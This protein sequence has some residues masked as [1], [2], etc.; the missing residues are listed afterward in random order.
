MKSKHLFTWLALL[1]CLA[2]IIHTNQPAA[3]QMDD[4]EEEL[5]LAVIAAA[6]L[7]QLFISELY[8]QNDYARGAVVEMR[9]GSIPDGEGLIFLALW[10]NGAWQVWF[11][12]TEEFR[13][14]MHAAPEG[15]VPEPLKVLLDYTNEPKPD[16][17]IEQQIN[18]SGYKLPWP[19]GVAYYISRAWASGSC[20]HA[21]QA[22]DAVMPIGREIVAARAGIV[23]TV[24]QQYDD[25]GCSSAN[26][27]NYIKIRHNPNDGLYDYYIHIGKNRSLVSPGQAVAQGQPIAYSDQIGYTCGSSTCP[28]GTCRNGSCNP[29]AHLHF[30]VSNSAGTRQYVRFDDVGDLVG[31]RT[32]TSG[33]YYGGRVPIGSG[34]SSVLYLDDANGDGHKDDLFLR[35]CGSNVASNRRYVLLSYPGGSRLLSR[36]ADG[37]SC[38]VFSDL[39]GAGPVTPGTTYE[40]R[41]SLG[42]SPDPSWP[43]PCYSATGGYGLC[44]RLSIAGSPPRKVFLPMVKR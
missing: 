1:V 19:G 6:P 14:L 31:C 17:E 15:L 33:N 23:D 41:F 28:A 38:V 18:A 40:T 3:T 22:M 30:H 26:R 27:Y 34:P 42:S 12:G 16:N 25:C 2:L 5:R 32:Y 13:N 20:N 4:R 24:V 11:E 43:I 10:E 37:G 7:D 9:D 8:M 35:A 21:S 44:D 39:E 36:E 29:G